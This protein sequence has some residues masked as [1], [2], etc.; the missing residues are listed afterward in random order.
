VFIDEL[1]AGLN[2]AGLVLDVQ[3]EKH[4]TFPSVFFIFSISALASGHKPSR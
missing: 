3:A 4:L 1:F 2:A